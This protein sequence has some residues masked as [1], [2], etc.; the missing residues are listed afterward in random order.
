[1]SYLD[2]EKLQTELYNITLMS[3]NDQNNKIL[4]KKNMIAVKEPAED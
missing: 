3:L 2:C 1:M 4:N